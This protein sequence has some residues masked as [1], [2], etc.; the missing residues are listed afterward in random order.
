MFYNIVY[1]VYLDMITWDSDMIS[2]VRMWE[3][4]K[5]L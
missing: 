1:T 2:E 5:S 3:S 4:E